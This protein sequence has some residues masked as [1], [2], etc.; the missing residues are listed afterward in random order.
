MGGMDSKTPPPWD[1]WVRALQAAEEVLLD[2]DDVYRGDP[3]LPVYRKLLQRKRREFRAR[4]R[5]LVERN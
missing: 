4:I 1:R 2:L 5:C 3:N